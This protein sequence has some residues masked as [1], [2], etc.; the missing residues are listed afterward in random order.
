MAREICEILLTRF[1][2]GKIV[3]K[4]AGTFTLADGKL[5]YHAAAP[6]QVILFQRLLDTKAVVDGGKLHISAAEAPAL[7]FHRL[8][9]TFSGSYL[10]AK[11]VT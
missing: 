5:T 2:W 3:Q 6:N 4:V 7:W 9:A 11:M 10:R 8:P 1:E